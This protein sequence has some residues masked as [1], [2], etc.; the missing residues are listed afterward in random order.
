MNA[1]EDDT[2]RWRVF[3]SDYYLEHRPGDRVRVR[4]FK[5][6]NL[7]PW[8]AIKRSPKS[9]GA[10]LALE[11]FKTHDEAIAYATGAQ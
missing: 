2:S 11:R 6:G 5:A 3:N 4:H 9:W 1:H 8:V 10:P 7:D